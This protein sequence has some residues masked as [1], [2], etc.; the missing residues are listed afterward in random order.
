[1]YSVW[2]VT[3]VNPGM[4]MVRVELDA[5]AMAHVL[6]VDV[7]R[8]D[9]LSRRKARLLSLPSLSSLPLSLSALFV[10][11]GRAPS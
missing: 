10:C 3:S 4:L 5:L 1:M 7:P 2:P 6:P 8:A 9:R 11:D